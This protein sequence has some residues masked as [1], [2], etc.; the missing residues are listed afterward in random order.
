MDSKLCIITGATDGIGKET[1]KM[2]VSQGVYVV[3]IGRN[4]EKGEKVREEIKKSELNANVDFIKCDLSIMAQVSDLASVLKKKFKKIDILINNAGAFFSK[5]ILTSEGLEATFALN[6][7]AYFHLTNLLLPKLKKQNDCR[8]INV[9]SDAHFGIDVEFDNLQGEN[10]YD[11]WKAYKRSKLLN[12]M[13][14]YQLA[15]QLSGSNI[16]VNCLHPG[17][18]ASKFGNNN[19][20][21]TG[22]G[23]RLAKMFAA[24]SVPKGAKTSLYLAVSSEVEGVSGKYFHK[25][26]TKESSRESYQTRNWEILWKT[27]KSILKSINT[28]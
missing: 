15:T 4:Q 23:L 18:V 27:S 16:T 20:G 13:F 1:A 7:L 3:I 14:T 21:I 9:A 5:R 2:L 28:M 26:K 17:F 11:G 19:Q 22:I 24:I 25:C 10:Q 6:H 8:I 12:I